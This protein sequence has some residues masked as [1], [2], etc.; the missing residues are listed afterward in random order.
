M[1]I[2]GRER[3]KKL[4]DATKVSSHQDMCG[5]VNH[6]ECV[7]RAPLVPEVSLRS[8]YHTELCRLVNNASLLRDKYL[9]WECPVEKSTAGKKCTETSTCLFSDY[10]SQFLIERICIAFVLRDRDKKDKRKKAG[11][12]G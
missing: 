2:Q 7:P 8:G 11:R 3:V 10:V 12:N 1:K 6:F 4:G 9:S 5:S